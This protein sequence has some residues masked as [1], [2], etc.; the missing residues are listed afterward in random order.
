VCAVPGG[1]RPPEAEGVVVRT[2]TIVNDAWLDKAPKLKVIGRA[3]VGLDNIDIAACKRHGV[4]VV[5]T[6]IAN[7]QAVVEYVW[8]LILDVVRPRPYLEHYVPPP[9][10]HQHRRD[11]IGRQLDELVLGVLGMG[12][13]G[14]RIAEVGH[15]IGM[16]VLYNDLLMRNQLAL[17]DDQPSELVDKA[18]LWAEADVLSIHV[19]G[20]AENRN[21]IDANV[22]AQLKPGCLII[23]A[24]RG[25]MIDEQ[26][27][28]DWANRVKDQGGMAVLDVQDPEPPAEDS[29]L[30]GIENIRLLPHLGARTHRAM[31]N[32]AWV[33]RDVVKVL[34][35]EEPTWEKS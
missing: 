13:I 4:R 20:R 28:A 26:A 25:M 34:E 17:P 27:L 31:S 23:N 21:L 9:V 33:V 7:T 8:A 32:M 6:P 15:A 29:P 16:R 24:A 18:T 12:N 14:R 30:F 10:Y 3:G 2:Y 5:F 19:D 35:G 22:L 11:D 1:P